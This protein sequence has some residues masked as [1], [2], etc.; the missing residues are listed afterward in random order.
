MPNII[1]MRV[2]DRPGVLDRIAGLIRRNGVNIKSITSGNIADGMN[3]ITIS[4]G[5]H[6]RLEVLG[7][8]FSEMSSVRHW[9]KCTPETHIIRELILARFNRD[10]HHLIEPEMRVIREE[11]G[12]T[13]VEFAADPLT[14]D[15]MIEKLR[16]Q[17]VVCSRGGAQ[18]I[19]LTEGDIRPPEGGI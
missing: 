14:V 17:G 6:A 12:L 2:Y 5:E 9:E 15:T 3:Q 10:Q 19:S 7:H 8:R 16:G 11:N 18:G 13:F 1:R 4:L